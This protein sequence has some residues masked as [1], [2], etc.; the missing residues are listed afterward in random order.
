MRKAYWMTDTKFIEYIENSKREL[1]LL[2]ESYRSEIAKISANLETDIR[3][4][5]NRFSRIQGSSDDII[6]NLNAMIFKAEK[7]KKTL[8][9]S[10]KSMD[11]DK[12]NTIISISKLLK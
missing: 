6:K 4:L 3:R 7:L 12:I 11:E 1:N 5:E 10:M 9:N 2:I 8:R